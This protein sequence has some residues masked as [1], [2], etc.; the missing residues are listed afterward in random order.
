M[1]LF[2]MLWVISRLFCRFCVYLIG[3]DMWYVF[4]L[5]FGVLRM[6]LV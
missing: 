1:L 5:M 4:G 2:I 3:E 6:L